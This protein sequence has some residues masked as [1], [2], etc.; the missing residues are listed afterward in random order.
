M[1]FVISSVLFSLY[2]VKV[3][4]VQDHNEPVIT[5]ESDE[6]SVT[7]PTKA[8][9]PSIE[10]QYLKGLT[11]KDDRD[12]DITDS[13]RID[14]VSHF[15]NDKRTVNYLVFDKAN[16]AATYSRTVT[17]SNY[18]KPRIYQ[19]GLLICRLSNASSY[20]L[21]QYSE[22][23]DSLD[24][25]L[26]SQ[27]MTQVKDSN[28]YYGDGGVFDVQYYVT[29]SAGDTCEVTQKV[30]VTDPMDRYEPDRYYPMLKH[31]TT[32][33]KVGKRPDFESM[34]TGVIRSE[35]PYTFSMYA[36][37]LP[38]EKSD[39]KIDTSKYDPNTPGEYF[40]PFSYT[41][42]DGIK[43]TVYLTVVVEG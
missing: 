15:V 27:V 41:S 6:I 29:N 9:D 22:A 16:H 1:Y 23:S 4:M 7:I 20:N 43:A 11:A 10:E 18:Q 34:I 3:R 21:L 33:A 12:G 36:D 32:Y 25:D 24:G 28:F 42:E 26:T 37:T 2:F 40:V 17:Y 13:I 19:D 5:A 35:R 14:S 8:S 38:L 30:I 31:Y 39:I